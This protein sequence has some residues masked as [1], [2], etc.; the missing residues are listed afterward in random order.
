[1]ERGMGREGGGTTLSEVGQDTVF[2]PTPSSAATVLLL[3]SY[4][5]Y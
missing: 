3:L 5:N 4:Y 1:M 2:G